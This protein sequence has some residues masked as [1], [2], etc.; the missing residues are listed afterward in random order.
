MMKSTVGRTLCLYME[1]N[2]MIPACWS[3]WV[4]R[5][6]HV[7]GTSHGKREDT[8]G[9][10]TA[11]A[12]RWADTIERTGS[13]AACNGTESNVI[14]RDAGRQRSAMPSYRVHRAAHYMMAMGLWRPPTTSDIRGPL[15][16]ATCNACM[17]CSYCFPDV[18]Q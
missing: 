16:L 18:S 5:K 13:P 2:F 9:R 14:R 1:S 12:R 15:P 11:T 17:S 6:R 4:H 7:L 3:M 8:L 10:S